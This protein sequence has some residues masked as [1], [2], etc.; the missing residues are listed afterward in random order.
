MKVSLLCFADRDASYAEEQ[1]ALMLEAATFADQN[2]FEA[3][4][5]PER[6]FHP[7]GGAYPNP[8]LAASAVATVTKN[9]R[10]RAGSVVLPLNDVLRVAED[11]SFVDNLSGGRVD[12]AFAT[13]WNPTDFVLAPERFAE[14]RRETL[15]M[16]DQVKALWQGRAILRRNGLATDVEIRTYP[17]PIQSELSVWLTCTASADGFT[18][19]GEKGYNVLTAMLFLTLEQ[20]RD[21]VSVYREAHCRKTGKR[22]TVTLMLHTYVGLSMDATRRIVGGPFR[23][24]LES[25]ISLWGQAV[26]RTQVR[27]KGTARD[28][29]RLV[30]LGFGRYFDNAALFGDVQRCCEF[31]RRV[32]EAGVD[33]IACLVDFGIERA[34]VIR[35]LRRLVEV[36]EQLRQS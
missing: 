1:Y 35:G 30:N 23:N 11:W 12:L 33:E 10:L 8:A 16:I 26:D 13:G 18:A 7:F 22:G 31:M 25:S 4:W 19:A 3:I 21:R 28:R 36:R 32:E 9:L 2:G 17:S 27:T 20:L 15:E 14:R 29:K 24:Y 34:E 6:H 5:I